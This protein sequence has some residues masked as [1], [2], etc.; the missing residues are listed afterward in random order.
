[1]ISNIEG[2][3]VDIETIIEYTFKKCSDSSLLL[4][5]YLKG[6]R[7]KHE[8]V[9]SLREI[10]KRQIKEVENLFSNWKIIIEFEDMIVNAL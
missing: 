1:M 4:D 8:K 10:M 6:K 9:E 3:G 2:E 7:Q 5:D